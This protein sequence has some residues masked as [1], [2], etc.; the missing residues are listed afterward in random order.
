MKCKSKTGPACATPREFIEAWQSSSS[1]AEVASKLR[2]KKNA[3][4]V[5]AFR[6]RK[7]G[8]PLKEFLS[9]WIELPDWEGLAEYAAGLAPPV[10]DLAGT[11]W[12]GSKDA[13]EED[14]KLT[15][16]FG[17]RGTV[18]LIDAQGTFEGSWKVGGNEVL[19]T[20]PEAA[21]RG[22]ITGD[23][24]SGMA[25]GTWNFIVTKVASAKESATSEPYAV[26]E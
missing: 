26:S 22:L 13:G 18:T 11:T 6:Y 1:V 12:T 8:V 23:T 5:R 20:F 4:R 16:V 7:M 3:C 9:A 17:Q 14:N 19:V 21:Y 15:F 2:S 24:I 10:P 25:D